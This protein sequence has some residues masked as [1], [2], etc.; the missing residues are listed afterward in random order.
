[1]QATEWLSRQAEAANLAYGYFGASTGGAA[2]LKAQPRAP[3][4]VKAIVCRGARADLG[5]EALPR[6]TAPTLLVVGELDEQVLE[7][8]RSAMAQMT[9]EVRLDIVSGAT[10]LFEEPGKL[11]EVV[12]LT[13]DWFRNHL[14]A[15]A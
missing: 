12:H 4:R 11:D 10:H 6:V 5:E 2:A 9:A 3:E 7:M 8:N 14:G 13:A 1:V 15:A